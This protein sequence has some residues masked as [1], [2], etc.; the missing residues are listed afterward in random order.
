MP[1]IFI[2]VVVS[3]VWCLHT[4]YMYLY[5][6]HTHVRAHTLDYSQEMWHIGSVV[7]WQNLAYR[8]FS[9]IGCDWDF[10]WLYASLF[11]VHSNQTTSTITIPLKM[12]LVLLVHASLM[13]WSG[14]HASA[15]CPYQLVPLQLAIQYG[16]GWLN[17]VGPLSHYSHLFCLFLLWE[18][19]SHAEWAAWE[20]VIHTYYRIYHKSILSISDHTDHIW[21]TDRS[22]FFGLDALS[23]PSAGH[24]R[25]MIDGNSNIHK[26]TAGAASSNALTIQLTG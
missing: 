14:S 17:Y 19:R 6:N 10:A 5:W 24:T 2:G 26:G 9:T 11:S 3:P 18:G 20:L 25:F 4:L 8:Q 15:V 16:L 7:L 22:G 13:S 1:H 21:F 23:T 12:L